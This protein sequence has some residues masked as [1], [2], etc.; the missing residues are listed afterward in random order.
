MAEQYNLRRLGRAD[1]FVATIACLLPILLVPVLLAR[2]REQS[3]RIVCAA[4]LSQIGKTMLVYAG[5]NERVLPRAGG[6]NSY[7]AAT[8]DWTASSR[9]AAFGLRDDWGSGRATISSSFYLLTKYYETPTRLFLCRGDKGAT[10]FRLSDHGSSL[11][12]GFSLADAWDFGPPSESFRHCSFSY[13]YPFSKYALTTSKD[14]NLAVAADRNPWFTS[15]AGEASLFTL[16]RP[17]VAPFYGTT[18]QARAGNAVTH[19]RDGQNILFLDG[20]VTFEKRAYC[21]LEKDNIYTQAVGSID[22][23]LPWGVVPHVAFAAPAN[24][25]DSVLVHDPNQF[26][27]FQEPP[28]R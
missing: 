4:N 1:A 22:R 20:R 10:E 7:W 12:A 15:P 21:A 16:F 26:P 13:H 18:E 19:G 27:P 5:D 6:F 3:I 23:G 25:K 8:P 2:P 11:P 9:K 17:D 14:P 28:R 24:P